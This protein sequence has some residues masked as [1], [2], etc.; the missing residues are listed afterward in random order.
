VHLPSKVVKVDSLKD[1]FN[2]NGRPI[3]GGFH[4][5]V[6]NI[7]LGQRVGA[8]VAQLL[9]NQF[10]IVVKTWRYNDLKNCNTYFRDQSFNF[11]LP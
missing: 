2:D 4:R 6:E 10:N 7:E 5:V 3:I 9:W 11:L 8:I 1:Y